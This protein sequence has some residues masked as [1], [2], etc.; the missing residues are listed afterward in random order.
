MYQLGQ[1]EAAIAT[2]D[3]ILETHPCDFIALANKGLVLEQLR[4]YE[5]AIASYERFLAVKPEGREDTE[6]KEKIRTR[7]EMLLKALLNPDKANNLDN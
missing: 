6:E 4:R 3:Q 7:K 5:E 1:Y 2:Y